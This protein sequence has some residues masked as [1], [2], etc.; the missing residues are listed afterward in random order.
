M[1]T[2]YDKRLISILA[3]ALAFF[4]FLNNPSDA[5]GTPPGGFGTGILT[6]GN[7]PATSVSISAPATITSWK[8]SPSGTGVNIIAG[9][10][11]VTANVDWQVSA[12]DLDA[13]TQG[14][15]TE[16]D[17]SKYIAS[18]PEKL[19]SHMK[20]SAQSGGYVDTGYE[21][22]LPT[23]GMIAKGNN[24]ETKIVDVPV[25]FKQPVSWS[26]EVLTSVH[27]YNIVVT[28]TISPYS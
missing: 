19:D 17:D 28:F 9:T 4:L 5:S 27:H 15:M 23:G 25:T 14:H 1:T 26:D 11:K 13:I 20:V 2:L 6:M 7:S 16:W 24:T 10:M 22:E 12:T 18:N 3:L 21:V 8:L